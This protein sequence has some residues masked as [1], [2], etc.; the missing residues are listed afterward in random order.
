[1]ILVRSVTYCSMYDEGSHFRA[2]SLIALAL[3]CHRTL[4]CNT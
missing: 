4:R 1:M 3:I 2:K